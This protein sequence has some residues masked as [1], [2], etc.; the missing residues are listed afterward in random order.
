MNL[1]PPNSSHVVKSRYD[2]RTTTELLRSTFDCRFRIV[3]LKQQSSRDLIAGTVVGRRFEARPLPIGGGWF[4]ELFSLRA[5]GNIKNGQLG[6]SH[7][8][9]RITASP[10]VIVG[11]PGLASLAV[12]SAV[13]AIIYVNA[14]PAVLGGFCFLVLLVLSGLC[15]F[16]NKWDAETRVLTAWLGRLRD[17]LETNSTST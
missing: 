9:V 17:Q 13:F 4:D 11:F 2:A 16:V 12:V 7:I 8:D 10:L 6:V 5:F 15:V 14:W 1:R 3:A